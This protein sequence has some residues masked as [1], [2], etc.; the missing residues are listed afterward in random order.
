MVTGSRDEFGKPRVRIVAG[1][2][3]QSPNGDPGGEL[4][5]CCTVTDNSGPPVK[6]RRTGPHLI[7]EGGREGGCGS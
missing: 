3:A 4:Q 1:E 6:T 5:V 2:A 7:D